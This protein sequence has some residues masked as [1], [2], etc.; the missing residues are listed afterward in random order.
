MGHFTPRHGLPV[1]VR[2]DNEHLPFELAEPVRYSNEITDLTIPRGFELDFASIPR[3]FWWLWPK[4]G[5]YARAA[6]V[7]DALYRKGDVSRVQ[8][9]ALFL[10][11]ME[12][13]GVRWCD[14]WPLYLAV[15]LFGWIAWLRLRVAED[16]DPQ[17]DWRRPRPKKEKL[18]RDISW[19]LL[20]GAILAVLL[21]S[22]MVFGQCGPNGCPPPPGGWGQRV[23]T[24]A[25]AEDRG[26]LT[27]PEAVRSAAASMV[28]VIH[29]EGGPRSIGSGV[30][31]HHEGEVS[32]VLTCAH[33]FTTPGCTFVRL[34]QQQLPAQIVQL[35][36]GNDVTLLRVDGRLSAAAI[37]YVDTPNGPLYA[38]GFGG[39]GRAR[40]V[41]YQIRGETIADGASAPSVVISGQVRSGDSG[42]P[43]F[44]E[45]GEVVGVVWGAASGETYAMH[46]G[47]VRAILA[48]VLARLRGDRP[49][50]PV[51]RPPVEEPGRVPA[52]AGPEDGSALTPQPLSPSAPRIDPGPCREAIALRK[53]V[54]AL[55]EKVDT[56]AANVAG[57]QTGENFVGT[58]QYEQHRQEVLQQHSQ[59]TTLIERLQSRVE[60]VAT[61]A[62]GAAK[63]FALSRLTELAVT[64]LGLGSPIGIGM[65]FGLRALRVWRGR[66]DDG[67]KGGSRVVPDRGRSAPP[68]ASY[69]APPASSEPPQSASRVTWDPAE[70]RATRSTVVVDTPATQYREVHQQIVP[71]ES[72]RFQRAHAWA[73][74]QVARKQPG[75]AGTLQ[76]LQSLI[77]QKLAAE[78][79]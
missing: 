60:E 8:A 27:I 46:R 69:D 61:S 11:I 20:I 1:L 40:L 30:V 54:E 33:L 35:D 75:A 49:L 25:P 55:A 53:D 67:P 15:R 79:V 26:A 19:P 32:Y 58:Q 70:Q 21:G 36:R 64:S 47:P 17:Y 76:Q 77:R 2:Y 71:V 42:G 12:Q 57:L 13:D 31:V 39:D 16:E 3:A 6:L 43:V 68:A 45:R 63:S 22:A 24:A 37:P 10:A 51:L 66:D 65:W 72:D 73:A 4:V 52:S 74:E 29:D 9:D 7:H 5:R 50:V 44:T 34:G 18:P 59:Q 41:G 48:R 14:R 28:R 56:L 78:A 38:G 62:A 23:P